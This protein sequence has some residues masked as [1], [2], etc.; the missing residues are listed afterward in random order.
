MT[1]NSSRPPPPPLPDFEPITSTQSEYILKVTRGG[2]TRRLKVW[3][4]E[5]ATP[6]QISYI[7]HG[8]V[9]RTFGSY[10]QYQGADAQLHPLD[11][12]SLSDCLSGGKRGVIKLLFREALVSSLHGAAARPAHMPPSKGMQLEL[13]VDGMRAAKPDLDLVKRGE[14]YSINAP[15]ASPRHHLNDHSHHGGRHATSSDTDWEC[16]CSNASQCDD[17]SRQS[18]DTGESERHRAACTEAA[19]TCGSDWDIVDSPAALMERSAR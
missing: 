10:L 18:G 11:V 2:D 9:Q 5:D 16:V 13:M 7:I 19:S 3:W 1:S 14:A 6:E 17:V 12:G 8:A 4:P 15:S